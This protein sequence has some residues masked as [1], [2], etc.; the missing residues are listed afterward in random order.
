MSLESRTLDCVLFE[1]AKSCSCRKMVGEA[2]RCDFEGK[3]GWGVERI[4]IELNEI[5]RAKEVQ[6]WRR[7]KDTL[8]C[9]FWRV[10]FTRLN[11]N[12][13]LW[14]LRLRST[15]QKIHPTLQSKLLLSYVYRTF[16]AISTATLPLSGV[17]LAISTR[18]GSP[19]GERE[20]S[21]WIF[22]QN[23]IVNNVSW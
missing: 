9:L 18:L 13:R 19:I 20:Y 5:S 14:R 17:S 15:R 8:S 12:A 3:G 2:K 6:E 4:E 11:L 10:Y 16:F 7:T 22:D 21:D 23:T 1:S